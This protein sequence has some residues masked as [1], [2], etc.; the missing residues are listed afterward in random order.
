MIVQN[1]ADEMQPP[2][3]EGDE[4]SIE[5]FSLTIRSIIVEGNAQT[6]PPLIKILEPMILRGLSTQHM[7]LKEQALDICDILFK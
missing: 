3:K 5:I 2:T 1:L 6:A 4:G 7:K